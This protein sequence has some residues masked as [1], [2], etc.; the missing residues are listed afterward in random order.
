MAF[1]F[2]SASAMAGRVWRF[3]FDDE[4]ATLSHIEPDA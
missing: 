4:I 2:V 1:L 3:P